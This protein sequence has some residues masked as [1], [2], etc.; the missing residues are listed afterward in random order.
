MARIAHAF[1]SIRFNTNAHAI[2]LEKSITNS[3]Y[4]HTNTHA[5]THTHNTHTQ[6]T[7]KH[8]LQHTQKC[9][10]KRDEGKGY[11]SVL[12]NATIRRGSLLERIDD[13]FDPHEKSYL[14]PQPPLLV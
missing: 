1:I 9:T 12:T 13:V 7:N 14:S 10:Q 5:H 6:H 2:L 4:S 3:K 8:V 11:N